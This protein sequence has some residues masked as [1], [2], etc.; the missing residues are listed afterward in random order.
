MKKWDDLPTK[1]RG[2]LI[3][4]SWLDADG[5]KY[6]QMRKKACQEIKQECDQAKEW[7][8]LDRDCRLT[9]LAGR[10]ISEVTDAE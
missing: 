4:L 2:L 10:M 8:L 3:Q 5:E 1:V 6:E 9:R 7:G